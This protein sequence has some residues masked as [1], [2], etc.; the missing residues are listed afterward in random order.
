MFI[1]HFYFFVDLSFSFLLF[2]KWFAE[3]LVFVFSDKGEGF[4]GGLWTWV[5]VIYIRL[6]V[7]NERRR[8]CDAVFCINIGV[9]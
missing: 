1:S 9:H 6:W 3:C 4:D 8:S 5:W 7:E 2:E